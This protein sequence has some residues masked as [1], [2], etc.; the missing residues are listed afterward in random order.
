MTLRVL[1]FFILIHFCLNV[2]A[3]PCDG[4]LQKLLEL[5]PPSTAHVIDLNFDPEP[6]SRFEISQLTSAAKINEAG[7]KLKD[8]GIAKFVKTIFYPFASYDA[9]TPRLLFPEADTVLAIDDAPFVRSIDAKVKPDLDKTE[10][11]DGSFHLTSQSELSE[12]V[13][14]AIVA[15]LQLTTKNFRLRKITAIQE[16]PEAWLYSYKRDEQLGP[17]HGI[18]EYDSGPGTAIKQYIHINNYISDELMEKQPWWYVQLKE[19]GFEALLQ[20]A[21]AGGIESY[22][23]TM[24][25]D[26]IEILTKNKGVFLDGDNHTKAEAEMKQKGAFTYKLPEFKGYGD[27][28]IVLFPN[29]NY[30]LKSFEEAKE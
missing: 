15:R 25:A 14:N 18:I 1:P 21:A 27:G 30:K 3:G 26:I 28:R 5:R 6:Y 24:T 22:T 12:S 29:R 17:T 23:K 7:H 10:V 4:N 9:A 8:A 20:K 2:F 19:H 16:K 13:A 11:Y